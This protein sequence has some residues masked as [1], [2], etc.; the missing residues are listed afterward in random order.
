M[1]HNM[2]F[3]HHEK[4]VVIKGKIKKI[5]NKIFSRTKFFIVFFFL[6]QP[7]SGIKSFCI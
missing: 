7:A 6:S 2:I 5:P 1:E 3:P 4:A